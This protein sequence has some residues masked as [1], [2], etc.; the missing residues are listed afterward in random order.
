M[1]LVDLELDVGSAL[2]RIRK[3][4]FQLGRR[5]SVRTRQSETRQSGRH[6]GNPDLRL[7]AHGESSER[8]QLLR[9]LR[10]PRR[11][12]RRN[13]IQTSHLPAERNRRAQNGTGRLSS[14]RHGHAVQCLRCRLSPARRAR[15]TASGS[16]RSERPSLIESTHGSSNARAADN[17][18]CDRLAAN[19]TRNVAFCGKRS[20]PSGIA[21][22][23]NNPRLHVE[24][25][26]TLRSSRLVEPGHPEQP[27]RARELGAK[28]SVVLSAVAVA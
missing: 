21:R 6:V 18:P 28:A 2:L 7:L 17:R 24:P 20:T 9:K 19:V 27:T 22:P 4:P 11:A 15:R 13:P 26:D 3:R 14:R 12:L 10:R 1:E 23:H 5:W 16:A 8:R 25:G